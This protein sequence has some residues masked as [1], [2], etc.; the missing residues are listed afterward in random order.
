MGE[1]GIGKTALLGHA[2]KVAAVDGTGEPG[3]V[4]AAAGPPAGF[5]R[6]TVLTGVPARGKIQDS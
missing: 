1:P 6:S 5:G 4:L 2:D 3:V